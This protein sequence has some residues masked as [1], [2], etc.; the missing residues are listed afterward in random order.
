MKRSISFLLVLVVLLN[1]FAVTPVY[2][3]TSSDRIRTL[4]ERY[5]NVQVINISQNVDLVIKRL[6]RLP[7]NTSHYLDI[8]F[9][10][11]QGSI[12]GI[13]ELWKKKYL[14]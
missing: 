6:L 7:P 11:T 10:E 13:K 14:Y 9:A 8:G 3:K 12:I 2:A 5:K 1:L 4:A